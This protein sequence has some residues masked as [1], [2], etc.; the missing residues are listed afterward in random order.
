MKTCS[1]RN[2]DSTCQ[3]D[4]GWLQFAKLNLLRNPFGQLAIDDWSH[5]A[6]V[7]CS[8]WVAMIRNSMANNSRVAL[9]FMG[10]C[11]RGKTTHLRAIQSHFP[12]SAFVYLPEGS[13]LPKVPHGCPLFID[14]AQRSPW[15]MRW[16]SFRRGVP[17][18]LGTHA[19][20]SNSLQRFGY[21]VTTVDV[22]ERFSIERL[23]K[24]VQRRIELARLGSNA[25]PQVTWEQIES[26][27]EQHGSDIRAIQDD[28]YE[29]F[30]AMV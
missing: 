3:P 25:V 7:D 23:A 30:Q 12:D 18:V 4:R 6:V 14:E 17:I 2:P 29:Q 21:R 19:D 20:L 24:I 13:R 26:L 8:E 9:Q 1:P 15:W 5:A 10:D 22:S 27:V 11:G 16:S 28:L